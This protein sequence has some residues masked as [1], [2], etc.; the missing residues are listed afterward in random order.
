MGLTRKYFVWV[1]MG[2]SIF[3]C[4]CRQADQKDTSTSN[5]ANSSSVKDQNTQSENKPNSKSEKTTYAPSIQLVYS[6]K[7]LVNLDGLEKMHSFDITKYEKIQQALVDGK[8]ATKDRF[9]EPEEVTRDE[10]L[11]IHTKGYLDSLKSSRNL[12]KYLEAPPL[13]FLGAKFLDKRMLS[14]FRRA[15]GGTILSARLAL[16]HGIA[17]NIGGGYHHAK[18]DRGEGF[19]VYADVPIA[20][21]KLQAEKLIKK[22]LVIDVDV[23]QGNGT[24]VCLAKDETTFTFSIHQDSI[25]PIPKERSDLDVEIT[26]GTTDDEY[27]AELNQHL[28]SVIK[29]SK[30]DICFIV[31]GCD[32]LKGD[33]LASVSMTNEGIVKR[34]ARIVEAC[35][36]SRIPVVLTLSGGYSKNA[37][38][39]QYLSIKN[40]IQ[41]YGFAEGSK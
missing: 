28:E 35:V 21:R 25:Y 33:P 12:S 20:I 32:T 14:C 31:G 13:R 36:A 5:S 29:K 2:L 15:T 10:L 38:Q 6:S 23:H 3:F 19:C 9:V 34:D 26:S 27:M 1:M 39:A 18:P 8:F 40:L 30:P 16:K 4:A 17:V 24:A 41:K 37:W 7:Y 22:A 11:L